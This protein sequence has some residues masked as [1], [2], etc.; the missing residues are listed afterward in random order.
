MIYFCCFTEKEAEKNYVPLYSTDAATFVGS[1][2]ICVLVSHHKKQNCYD[3][4]KPV[5]LCQ[6]TLTFLDHRSLTYLKKKMWGDFFWFG[7]CLVLESLKFARKKKDK[8]PWLKFM[9]L[10]P[11]RSVTESKKFVRQRTSPGCR[12]AMNASNGIQ[13]THLGQRGRII[14]GT[15]ASRLHLRDDVLMQEFN[16]IFQFYL[17]LMV[18][19]T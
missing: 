16:S 17:Y 18:F 4:V 2:T 5:N 19:L 12:H 11:R 3:P 15:A 14:L 6:K 10:K 9:L 1:S 8:F 7:C 13:I